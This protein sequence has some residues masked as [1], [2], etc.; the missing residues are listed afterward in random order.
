LAEVVVESNG[1]DVRFSGIA[2]FSLKDTLLCGQ[3]FRWKGS[4]TR[5]CK[6]TGVVKGRVLTVRQENESLLLEG[7][8]DADDVHMTMDYFALDVNL[9]EIENKLREIDPAV[10]TAIDFAPGI[11]LL[12]Q[13]PWEAMVTFIIS[14]R[15]SIPLIRRSVELL[16]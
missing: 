4:D 8:A 16:G 11:R 3:A 12:R 14:A 7:S 13:D 15:N 1:G 6:Y 9:G 5:A 10:G 2:P